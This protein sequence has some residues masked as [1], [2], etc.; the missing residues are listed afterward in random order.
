MPAKTLKAYIVSN[1][2]PEC[3]SIQYATTNVAARRQGAAEIDDDFGSVSCKRLHWADEF[4]SKPIPAKAYIDNGWRISCTNCGDYVSDESYRADEDGEDVPHDPVFRGEHVFCSPECQARHDASVAEQN[5]K[6]ADF[7][8]RARAARPDLQFKEFRGAYPYITM[9]G[10]FT[11]DGAK[12]GGSVRDDG[13]GAL[14]WFIASGDQAIWDAYELRSR[15][16]VA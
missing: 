16:A 14:K 10:K 6:F 11:F 13:D 4:A 9:T 12:Y 2:D 1:G 7:E 15:E 3:D 8:R 5:A